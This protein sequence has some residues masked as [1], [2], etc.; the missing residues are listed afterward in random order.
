[1]S[2]IRPLAEIVNELIEQVTLLALNATIEEARAGAASKGFAVVAKE[3][4]ELANQTVKGTQE[5]R[6]HIEE[7]PAAIVNT[8]TEITAITELDNNT[9]E[10]QNRRN[11]SELAQILEYPETMTICDFLNF[12]K[13]L[14]QND[15]D[16]A[17]FRTEIRESLR[18]L[19]DDSQTLSIIEPHDDSA[20]TRNEI[21]EL[22]QDLKGDSQELTILNSRAQGSDRQQSLGD[23]L[24]CGLQKHANATNS[25]A[26]FCKLYPKRRKRFKN[27]NKI[28]QKKTVSDKYSDGTIQFDELI[29]FRT[30]LT[31][32]RSFGIS[33]HST[34]SLRSGGIKM[35]KK[36]YKRFQFEFSDE[37]VNSLER[38]LQNTDSSTKADAI[39][40]ALRFYEYVCS[41][42]K[43]GYEFELKKEDRTISI[44]I[45]LVL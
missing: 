11:N 9:K 7:V 28:V 41:K 38:V 30:A 32:L 6:S 34:R 5:I 20:L 16:W 12:G 8:A 27:L 23:L 31:R 39:R 40:K 4:K 26:R 21:E 25:I 33:K 22:L 3:V 24:N 43:D 17:L 42:A 1:M 29:L 18:D 13:L 35:A 10:F 15:D 14:P 36:G 19:K 37:A 2:R 44:P 45:E